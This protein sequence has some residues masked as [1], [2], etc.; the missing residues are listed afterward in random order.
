LHVAVPRVSV[1]QRGPV[2]P[3]AK[4]HSA[5]RRLHAPTTLKGV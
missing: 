5:P 1:S 3:G 2:V 4:A